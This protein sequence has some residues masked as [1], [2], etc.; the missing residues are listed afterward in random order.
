M[1]IYDLGPVLP[2]FKGDWSVSIKYERNNI[3]Y[4][5]GD[6]YACV[7]D[8][9][10]KGVTPGTNENHWVLVVKGS[11]VDLDGYAPLNHTHP[12]NV[13]DPNGVTG[14]LP[15]EKGGTSADNIDDAS[16]N[17]KYVRF[18]K[19]N[20][21]KYGKHLYTYPTATLTLMGGSIDDTTGWSYRAK[22]MLYGEESAAE[23]EDSIVTNYPNDH[24]KDV[25]AQD[26]VLVNAD[27]EHSYQFTGHGP[28]L[29]HRGKRLGYQEDIDNN[30]ININNI[31]S[32]ELP[33]YLKTTGGTLTGTVEYDSDN[34]YPLRLPSNTSSSIIGMLAGKQQNPNDNI[35]KLAL[36]GR[37]NKS[38]PG[39]FELQA[40]SADGTV[41]R[42]LRGCANS[43]DDH[44][45]WNDK[46][47]AFLNEVPEG[48]EAF[49]NKSN[50]KVLRFPDGTQVIY[51]VIN[52]CSARDHSNVGTNTK[53]AYTTLFTLDS[54]YQFAKTF[55]V[56]CNTRILS[57]P[58]SMDNYY[59]NLLNNVVKI[60]PF[61]ISTNKFGTTSAKDVYIPSKVYP[62]YGEGSSVLIHDNALN[63]HFCSGCMQKTTV[64]FEF[65]AIPTV[66]TDY[67]I[68]NDTSYWHTNELVSFELIGRWK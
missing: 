68:S 45:L 15:I 4:Y 61:N 7:K 41:A 37:N 42:I 28:Y 44:L 23:V 26:W 6:S 31:I 22:L 59:V 25:R 48:I 58:S 38:L 56:L 16:E 52:L 1:A 9:G 8:D 5:N 60:H 47:L 46:K 12:L 27:G 64:S 53:E 62:S 11:D 51:G 21:I 30:T 49:T 66:N 39:C 18:D 35:A 57:I 10:S 67:D 33:K 32:D 63:P 20:L 43:T 2:I 24:S 40:V 19:E 29:Y 14:I 55:P 36:Y 17:L 54:A 34:G 50:Y 3:V 65:F 13:E